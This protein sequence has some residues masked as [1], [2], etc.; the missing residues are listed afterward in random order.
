V[1]SPRAN[2]DIF[3]DVPLASANENWLA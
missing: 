3:P 1:K 2:I